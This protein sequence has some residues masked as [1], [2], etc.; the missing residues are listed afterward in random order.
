MVDDA[1]RQVGLVIDAGSGVLFLALAAF[2]GL[3]RPRTRTGAW[4]A[5]FAA[6][7][8]LRATLDNGW[9]LGWFGN[10]LVTGQMLV[11]IATAVMAMVAILGL[12]RS[13][14]VRMAWAPLALGGVA[15]ASF[16][17]ALSLGREWP[18]AGA[19]ATAAAFTVGL[20]VLVVIVTRAPDMAWLNKPMAPYA[21]AFTLVNLTNSFGYV[22]RQTG[23]ELLLFALNWMAPVV[24]MV[25]ALLQLGKHSQRAAIVIVVAAGLVSLAWNVMA[26]EN[27]NDKGLIGA[28][29]IVAVLAVGYAIVQNRAFDLDVKIRRSLQ[30][31]VLVSFF[32]AAF[33]GAQTFV[34][35]YFTESGGLLPG[36]LATTLLVLAIAPLQRLAAKVGSAAMPNA[37]PIDERSQADRER[38]YR[39]VSEAAWEDGIITKKELT[40][41]DVAR[42]ELGLDLGTTARIDSQVRV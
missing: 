36:A 29:R 9:R 4:F 6:S 13:L 30:R 33:A 10:N 25:W 42:E 35:E 23:P 12:G 20:W 1:W 32:I 24:A 19:S 34:G 39:R 31:S 16:G 5:F 3:K 7:L 15:G 41:L 28:T 40:L 21:T 37:R 8:G 2:V 27:V 22:A 11:L 26:G 38:L 18:G 14:G 17:L